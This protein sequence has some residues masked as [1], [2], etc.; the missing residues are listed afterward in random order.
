ML[1]PIHFIN[2]INLIK[3]VYYEQPKGFF[4]NKFMFLNIV[5]VYIIKI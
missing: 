2:I 3:A 5:V 4:K 1:W